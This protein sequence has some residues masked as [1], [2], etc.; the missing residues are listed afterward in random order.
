[1][2]SPAHRLFVLTMVLA[3]GRVAGAQSL[4]SGP[5]RAMDG[6]VLVSGEAVATFSAS[7]EVAYFNYTDYEHNALRLL[8]VSL[9]AAWQPARR[10]AFVG[11][12]R[13]EDLNRPRAYAA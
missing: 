8:R 9:S 1:M 6:Q 11:E 5:I 13:S 12:L 3:L 7:D 10:I 4:P 2:S